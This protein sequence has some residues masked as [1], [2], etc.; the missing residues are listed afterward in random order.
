MRPALRVLAPGFHTTVQDLGRTGYQDIGV[1]VSGALDAD[2]LRLANALVGN[3]PAMAAL[4]ILLSGPTFEVAADAV[5]VA[6]AGP[7]ASLKV[8]REQAAVVAGG[9]SLMLPRGEIFQVLV[10]QQSA[11]CYLAVEG[12]I[13]VPLVL[14]SASTYVRAALG[15][16]EGRPLRRDDT[17]PLAIESP[18]ER[19]EWGLPKPLD[20]AGGDLPIR[21]VLGPQR[22]YFAEDATAALLGEE[23]R[24]SQSADRM[25]MRLDGPRL[26]HRGGWDIVSDAIVTGAVQVPGSGQVIVL[27][28]DHQTTGGY[29]K[30]ATVISAD[31]PVVGR[32]RPGDALRFAAVTVEEAE[33]I[34]R[35]AE[36]SFARL[37]AALEPV[38]D[39]GAIDLL[40]LY[41]DNLISGVVSGVD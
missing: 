21:I 18:S 11:C 4:E 12:G 16:F 9:Q 2:S 34:S 23:F 40:S 15:G 35:E 26:H 3:P 6:L 27:L 22:E 13:A 39:G 8:G 37:V 20:V 30:I 32:R 29:P 25:G 1:P 10:N 41:A 5:R 7:G 28:A 31:L 17:V 36:R 24:I 19:V 33:K 14:G 38:S